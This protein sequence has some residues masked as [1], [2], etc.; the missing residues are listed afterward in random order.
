MMDQTA[1]GFTEPVTKVLAIDLSDLQRQAEF[2]RIT[3]QLKSQG[4]TIGGS[5]SAIP[6]VNASDYG[7]CTIDWPSLLICRSREQASQHSAIAPQAFG[8][9]RGLGY[10]RLETALAASVPEGPKVDSV[11]VGLNWTLVRAGE[12][13]GIARSP[14]RGTEGART[15]RPEGGFEGRSLSEIASYLCSTDPLSRSIGLAA[16]NAYWNRAEP[17]E[18]VKPYICAGGGLGGLEAPGIGV[19]II[20]GF[21]GAQKKLPMARI[22]E[23]E[24]KPGDIPIQEAQQAY[25]QA[26][27]LAIT[28]QTL[29]NGSLEPILHASQT[30]P[31]RMLVGPSSPACPLV[32]GHGIDETFGAVIIDPDAAEKFII[33]TGTMIMLDHIA[34]SFCLRRMSAVKET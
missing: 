33:E 1:V 21:R 7:T 23:R 31:Q 13:C 28:A 16:I 26:S 8:I 25:E 34:K 30:V 5:D 19:V 20:G 15:L 14:S 22:V 3:K 18:F 6:L 27:T 9:L 10:A 12:F 4:W 17:V 2:D 24:P 11:L 29:M 32:F